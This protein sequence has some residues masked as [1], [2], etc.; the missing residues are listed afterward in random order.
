MYTGA[1]V[2]RFM[3]VKVCLY[4]CVQEHMCAH[5]YGNQKSSLGV[6]F[7][8]IAALFFKTGSLNGLKLL[9]YAWLAL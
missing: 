9:D 6:L 8:R 5:L 2:C 7:L 4:V 3:C 1:Y